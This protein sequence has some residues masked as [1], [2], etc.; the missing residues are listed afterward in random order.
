MYDLVRT[1]AS[2]MTLTTPDAGSSRRR[3]CLLAATP[4]EIRV[5]PENFGAPP[6]SHLAECSVV[7]DVQRRLPRRRFARCEAFKLGYASVRK[8]TGTVQF[9]TLSIHRARGREKRL[10]KSYAGFL[11]QHR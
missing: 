5:Y 9:G 6:S 3:G 7:Y 10:H 11:K 1:S 4:V 8:W 2:V